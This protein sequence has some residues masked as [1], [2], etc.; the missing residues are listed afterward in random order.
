[1]SAA[2]QVESAGGKPRRSPRA[3]LA[4]AKRPG[5]GDWAAETARN[6][7]RHRAENPPARLTCR[8]A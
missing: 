1:M 8:A 3:V 7:G 6:E 5:D 4:A 2:G